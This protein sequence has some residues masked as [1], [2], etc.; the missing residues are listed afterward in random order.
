MFTYILIYVYF[1]VAYELI[2][3]ILAFSIRV[4]MNCDD[5]SI[6]LIYNLEILINRIEQDK[7]WAFFQAIYFVN[8][9]DVLKYNVGYKDISELPADT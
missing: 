6:R 5:I 2:L 7:T 3:A 8:M 1:G 4:G 9:S